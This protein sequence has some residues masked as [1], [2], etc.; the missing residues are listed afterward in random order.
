MAWLVYN[1]AFVLLNSNSKNLSTLCLG[2]IVNL[3]IYITW[4][5]LVIWIFMLFETNSAYSFYFLTML[6]LMLRSVL[7]CEP[8]LLLE[9]SPLRLR[10]VSFV[11][12]GKIET[13]GRML[14]HFAW[15]HKFYIGWKREEEGFL[16]FIYFFSSFFFW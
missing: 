16:L 3:D 13:A 11:L 10:L 5:Q 15:R 14:V 8:K 9:C 4:T 12:G 6:L 7:A 2:L 1:F